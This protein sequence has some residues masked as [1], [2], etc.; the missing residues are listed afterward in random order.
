LF[1]LHRIPLE[2]LKPEGNSGIYLYKDTA[3]CYGGKGLQ[4]AKIRSWELQDEADTV[5]QRGQWE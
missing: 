4:G 2:S 3:Y 1:S 5:S